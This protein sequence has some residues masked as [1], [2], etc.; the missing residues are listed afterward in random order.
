MLTVF[1]IA[2]KGIAGRIFKFFI[3][4]PMVL[5]CIALLVLGG[6]FGYSSGYKSA[7]SAAKRKY[8][9]IVAKYAKDVQARNDRIAE[10]EKDSH[11]AAVAAAADIAAT[12]DKIETVKNAYEKKL[13]EAAKKTVP[14][15]V[16]GAKETTTVYVNA[17]GDVSC[18][19][20]P[21]EFVFTINGMVDAVNVNLSK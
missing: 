12:H 4:H 2:V 3:D 19:R 5:V 16:P 8:E 20:L 17:T 13:A 18:R 11:T 1:L 21:D 15:L 14:I 7:E 10:I 6:Y 9:P